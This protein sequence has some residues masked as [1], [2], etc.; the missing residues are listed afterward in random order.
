MVKLETSGAW[1][2]RGFRI[3]NVPDGVPTLAP[4]IGELDPPPQPFF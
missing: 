1:N 4:E 3:E 2:P